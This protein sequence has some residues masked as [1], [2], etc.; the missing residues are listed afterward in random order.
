[1][2]VRM[3][4]TLAGPQGAASAGQE[5]DLDAKTATALIEGGYARAVKAPVE[6]AAL[7]PPEKAVTGR[8]K[9]KRSP[10]RAGTKTKK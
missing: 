3:I 1:M 4:T 5:V 6:T 7:Q 2:R 8:P 9:T 10:R